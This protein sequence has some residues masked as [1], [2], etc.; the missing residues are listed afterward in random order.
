MT[1][2][3]TFQYPKETPWQEKYQ[4]LTEQ[5]ENLRCYLVLEV[6][7]RVT[8]GNKIGIIIDK[9]ISLTNSPELMVLWSEKSTRIE[10]P[11][12]L[13]LEPFINPNIQIRDTL[14]LNSKHQKQAGK[15]FEI[16][17]LQGNGWVLTTTDQQFHSDYFHAFK[18]VN[19]K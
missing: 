12:R 16:K 5:I 14:I 11:K 1:N 2:T 15:R 9:K 8:D 13:K 7:T 17:E 10:E 19:D 18:M 3:I 6:G 4:M